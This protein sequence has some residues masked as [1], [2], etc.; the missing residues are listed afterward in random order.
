M[1]A[2]PSLPPTKRRGF[3]MLLSGKGGVGKSVVARLLA[4]FLTDQGDAPLAFDVDPVNASF[5]AVP[6]FKAKSI[7]LLDEDHKINASRFDEIV[8]DILDAERSV[9][10]DSGASSYLPLLTYME[11]NDLVTRLK[12]EGFDVFLHTII[13]GGASLDFTTQ[14]FNDVAKNFGDEAKVV[15]WLNHVWEKIA[16]DGKPFTEWKTYQINRNRLH[17]ILEIPKMASDMSA[18]DFSAML[19]ENL[20]FAE[21]TNPQSSFRVMQ[22][23][24]LMKVRRLMFA[25]M[26]AMKTAPSET[27]LVGLP[28]KKV[29]S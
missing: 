9:V 27:S 26:E 1:T 8:E 13:N 17:C 15:V 11:E 22:R 2:H 25:G 24:R 23:S 20:S 16:R 19:K 28:V 14:N 18:A 6:A 29:V 10:M 12:D 21:A 4:E 3:H 7:N 5:A